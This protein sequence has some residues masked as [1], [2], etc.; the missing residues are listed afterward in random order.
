LDDFQLS[1]EQDER[2][3]G[4]QLRSIEICED[5]IAIH[6][7]DGP[8][9]IFVADVDTFD[10]DSYADIRELKAREI[11]T[12]PL[13]TKKALG[14]LTAAQYDFAKRAE[15]ERAREVKR[16]AEADTEQRERAKL[17]ELKAKYETSPQESNQ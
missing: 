5:L 1:S 6:T 4:K 8:T 15:I 16:L 3:F 2:I 7:Q 9:L 17:A 14:L 10:E 11:E 12:L 13:V